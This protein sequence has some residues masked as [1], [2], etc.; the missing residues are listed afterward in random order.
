[1]RA[2][3]NA[4]RCDFAK[5]WRDAFS[6]FRYGLLD[7]AFLPDGKAWAVGG[8]GTIFTSNDA[9]GS[10]TKVRSRPRAA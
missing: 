5:A 4:P 8:G 2:E 1:M 9:G 6:F 7:V 10:W 3:V